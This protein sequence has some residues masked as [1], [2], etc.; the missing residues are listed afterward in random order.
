[1]ASRRKEQVEKLRGLGPRSCVTCGLEPAP[2][3]LQWGWKV[4]I[5]RDESYEKGYW[6]PVT[7]PAHGG[8]DAI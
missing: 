4:R 2:G 1:M 6:M 5:K 7:C 3:P 8:D